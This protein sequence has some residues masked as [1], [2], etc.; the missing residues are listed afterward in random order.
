MSDYKNIWVLIDIQNGQAKTLE[1]LTGGRKLAD[2]VSEKLVA[3]VIGS[4]TDA[5]VKDAVANG[6]DQILVVDGA[7]YADYSTEGYTYALEQLAGKYKPAALLIGATISGRD[8]APRLAARLKTG[9]AADCTDLEIDAGTGTIQ[10]TRPA[11]GGNELAVIET[12]GARPQLGTVRPS[13]FKRGEPDTARTAEIIK[14]DIALPAGTIR[15]SIIERIA[16]VAEGIKLEDAE[17][18]VSGGRGVGSTENF[19]LLKE[20]A[21]LMGGAV[22]ASRAAVD[23]GWISHV[24]QVGQTG[25]TVSPKLYI[26]CGISGAIQHLAGMSGSDV[27]IAINRDPDAP[28]FEVA[29]YG[30]VGNIKDVLPAL[31]EAIKKLKA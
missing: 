4:G 24:A 30:I 16:E 26:A 22:G 19:A 17:V 20:L 9:L 28:I 12:P 13:A 27:V 21:D 3:V 14:E 18:V 31:T 29:D 6:A 7:D 5:A 8:L 1:L 2:A 15:T 25:K 10:W 11:Y 23:A